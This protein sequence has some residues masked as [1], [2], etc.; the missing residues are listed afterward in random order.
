MTVILA[1]ANRKGGVGKSTVSTMLAHSLAIWGRQRV[2]VIDL[3]SQANSSLILMGGNGWAQARIEERTAADYLFEQFSSDRGDSAR[4][5]FPQVGD[6]LDLDGFVPAID[7][8]PGS[9][10]ME[11]YE[12]DLL[13]RLSGSHTDFNR[14]AET[15]K[16]R[17]TKRIEQAGMNYDAV[18][19]D[20]P[21][22]VSFA[23]EAA[24][25]MADKVVV[26]FRPDYV[27]VFAVDRI[28]RMI[29]D[30]PNPR[31]LQEIPKASRRYVTLVNLYQ[32]KPSHQ[33]LI[34]D[35]GAF[36]PVMKTRIPQSPAVANAFDWERERRLIDKKY[37][38]AVGML[39]ELFNELSPM[40]KSLGDKKGA[41]N[42]WREKTL[43]TRPTA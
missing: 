29:E 23:M 25:A 39:R 34:E 15:I 19:V 27:S 32:Q 35:I 16:G 9:L 24:L 3:D 18:I 6:V 28:A 20:C 22:G 31:A 12:R 26:P 7:L 1:I 41:M 13:H 30:A 42:A 43:Y 38:A 4:Y 11:N 8:I 33:R 2:L 40:V 5:I 21:P 17:I 36:H 14:V 10:E 37:G